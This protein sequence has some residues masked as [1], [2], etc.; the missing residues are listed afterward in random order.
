MT[1]LQGWGQYG[2]I[3]MKS[4]GTTRMESDGTTRMESD[5]VTF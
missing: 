1:I 3:R 4:D 2:D 5:E